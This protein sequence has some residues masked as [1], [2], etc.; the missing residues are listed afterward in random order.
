MTAAAADTHRRGTRADDEISSRALVFMFLTVTLGFASHR[1]R[2]IIK[3]VGPA[4]Q[5]LTSYAVG[6]VL[7]IAVFPTMYSMILESINGDVLTRRRA[8]FTAFLSVIISFATIGAGV[9]L[10]W[11]LDPDKP[12]PAQLQR[13]E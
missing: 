4:W 7:V 1:L 11:L 10:G 6:G 2:P 8:V 13:G 3:Q 12:E 9:T 5:E